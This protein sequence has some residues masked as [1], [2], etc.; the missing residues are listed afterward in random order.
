V[1]ER[2]AQLSKGDDWYGGSYAKIGHVEDP[3]GIQVELMEFVVPES[4]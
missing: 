1:N 3:G 2:Y 4:K